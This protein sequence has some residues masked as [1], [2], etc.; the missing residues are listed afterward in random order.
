MD[1]TTAFALEGQ[2][3]A[4]GARLGMWLFILSEILLFGGM[5][6]LYSAYRYKTLSI[7][8]MHRGNSMSFSAP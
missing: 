5:F 1:E 6:I 4:T 3:D 8:I 2:R 7:F